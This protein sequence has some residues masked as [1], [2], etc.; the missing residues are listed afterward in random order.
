MKYGDQLEKGISDLA[1][2]DQPVNA[3]AW[4]YWFTFDVMG[5]FAFARS[6]GMLEFER[7]HTVVVMLRKA[8]R[9]LGPLSPVLWLAQIGFNILPRFWVVRDWFA[10]LAWCRERMKERIQVSPRLEYTITICC[11]NDR[12]GTLDYSR[13]ARRFPVVDRRV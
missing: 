8:M 6:F 13:Q 1:Q 10:M 11:M 12:L 4:F 9:L 5:E 7:W 3:S 2:K